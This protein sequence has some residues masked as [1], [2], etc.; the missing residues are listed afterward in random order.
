MV[1]N[2]ARDVISSSSVRRRGVRQRPGSIQAERGR[3][4]DSNGADSANGPDPG[5][6]S[7]DV[8]GTHVP[9]TAVPGTA[10]PAPSSPTGLTATP[11][12]ASRSARGAGSRP[13]PTLDR[14]RGGAPYAA[15]RHRAVP[16]AVAHA[17]AQPVVGG[18]GQRNVLLLAR[19]LRRPGV[20][21]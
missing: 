1:G 9:G 14:Q 7:V 8:P 5:P 20:V 19:P 11:H 6:D 2:S 4:H 15:V 18:R 21:A 12:E 16:R 10:D 17:V 3:S 13:L